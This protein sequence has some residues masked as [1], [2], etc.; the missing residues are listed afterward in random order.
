MMILTRDKVALALV[1]VLLLFGVIRLGF[2][3]ER[4]NPTS[5]NPRPDNMTRVQSGRSAP[6]PNGSFSAPSIEMKEC[7]DF[8]LTPALVVQECLTPDVFPTYPSE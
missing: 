8:L 5:R 2:A 7:A 6:V 4:A 3:V 1:C